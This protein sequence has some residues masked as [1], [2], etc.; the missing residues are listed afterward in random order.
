M[1]KRL[2]V[3]AGGCAWKGLSGRLRQFAAGLDM[4]EMVGSSKNIRG[5]NMFNYSGL[6]VSTT[7]LA[8]GSFTPMIR[9]L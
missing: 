5:I 2:S 4:P 8:D 3:T 9:L 1:K 6:T 7:R